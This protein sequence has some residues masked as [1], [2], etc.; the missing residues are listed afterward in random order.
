MAQELTARQRLFIQEF[1]V[2]HNA[3]AAAI[4]AGY[5]AQ[6]AANIGSQLRQHPI[7]K[8]EI[9]RTIEEQEETIRS[10]IQTNDELVAEANATTG[11]V[12]RELA[13]IAFADPR[14]II[15]WDEG[16]IK[17]NKSED[18]ADEDVAAIAEI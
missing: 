12:I 17:L 5:S 2:D 3:A 1:R 14:K 18:L 7:V 15:S 6:T 9:D 8:P 16:G 13:R 10:R 11:K 4:R